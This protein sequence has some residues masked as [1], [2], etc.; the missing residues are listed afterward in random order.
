[1]TN[2]EQ[3]ENELSESLNAQYVLGE[4]LNNSI[5]TLREIES[6]LETI[7]ANLKHSKAYIATLEQENK[8]LKSSCEVWI[9][10]SIMLDFK[11]LSARN[12]G[13]R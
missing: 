13:Q 10:R 7:N 6:L 4:K 9:K 1:M 12:A 3:L 8:T 5:K 11:V 2:I